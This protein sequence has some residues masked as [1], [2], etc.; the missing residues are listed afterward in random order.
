MT[1]PDILFALAEVSIALAGFSAVVVL[2]KRGVSG[3]WLP[4]DADRFHGMLLHAMSAVFFCIFPSLISVFTTDQHFIWSIASSG[5]GIQILVH[6][7]VILRLPSTGSGARVLL[8]L[9]LGAIVLQVLN[10]TGVYFSYEFRAYLGGVLWHVFQAGVL[11]V[12]LVWVPS[13][14]IR[15]G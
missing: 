12:R 7:T 5:L 10:V 11:F 6:C 15:S 3:E 8:L 14:D 9:G 1:K 13:S 2:F 4:A